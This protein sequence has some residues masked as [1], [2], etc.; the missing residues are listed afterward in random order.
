M[1]GVS[2]RIDALYTR[3]IEQFAALLDSLAPRATAGLEGAQRARITAIAV[4]GAISE[5]ALFWLLSDYKADR[6][7][8]VK[9]TSHVLRGTVG[10]SVAPGSRA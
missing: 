4:I 5:A 9:A 7:V 10:A 6:R 3:R 8:L 1:L 2:P